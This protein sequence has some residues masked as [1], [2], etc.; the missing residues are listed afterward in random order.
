VDFRGRLAFA[1]NFEDGTRSLWTSD[2]TEAGTRLV[3]DVSPGSEGSSPFYLTAMNG[4]VYFSAEDGVYGRELWS[5]DGTAAGTVRVTDLAPGEASASPAHLA[6]VQGTLFFSARTAEHG[7]EVWLS[8]GTEAGTRALREGARAS[9]PRGFVR[10]G[11]DVFF[12]AEGSGGSELWA[13]PFRPVERCE[14][15]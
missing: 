14:Q 4:R 7:T 1:A 6:A 8:D 15:P 11:W 3:K 10:S 13:V 9:G 5:S 2:G 12:S